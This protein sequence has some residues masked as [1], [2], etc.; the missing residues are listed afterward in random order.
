MK[1]KHDNRKSQFYCSTKKISE[2]L[3]TYLCNVLNQIKFPKILLIKCTTSLF[4][5][6]NKCQ[7]NMGKKKEKGGIQELNE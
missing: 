2:F 1:E 3:K 5:K 4:T 7:S 6:I